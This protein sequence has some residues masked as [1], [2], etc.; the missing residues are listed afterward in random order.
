MN[1]GKIGIKM[2]SFGWKK[3]MKE[4]NM[5]EIERGKPGLRELVLLIQK[6]F[7]EVNM[8]VLSLFFQNIYVLFLYFS[9][10]NRSHYEIKIYRIILAEN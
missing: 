1:G 10:Y 2:D 8:N 7:L 3:K 9:S 5:A 6:L 4:I